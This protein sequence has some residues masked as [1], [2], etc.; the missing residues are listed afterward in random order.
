MVSKSRLTILNHQELEFWLFLVFLHVFLNLTISHL[1]MLNLRTNLDLFCG[2]DKNIF[3]IFIR[4]WFYFIEFIEYSD[5][6]LYIMIFLD[7]CLNFLVL[8]YPFC[9]IWCFGCFDEIFV[10]IMYVIVYLGKVQ[11]CLDRDLRL[12][13]CKFGF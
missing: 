13:I 4:I 3:Q 10:M 1:V 12:K 6:G 5:Q 8:V 2:L 7:Y 11:G 9:N